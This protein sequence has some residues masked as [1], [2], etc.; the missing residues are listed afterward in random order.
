M[1]TLLYV[2]VTTVAGPDGVSSGWLKLWTEDGIRCWAEFNGEPLLYKW[3]KT[4]R[5]CVI[6]EGSDEDMFVEV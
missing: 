1:T 6:A 3:M 2:G 5:G 4:E